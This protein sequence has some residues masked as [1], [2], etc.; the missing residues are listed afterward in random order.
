[1]EADEKK[2]AQK[3]VDCAALHLRS[4]WYQFWDVKETDW[5]EP[6]YFCPYYTRG[7]LGDAV[8]AMKPLMEMSD[9]GF[10][11]LY[12]PPEKRN[13][14]KFPWKRKKTGEEQDQG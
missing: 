11:Y 10:G 4:F 8:E 12:I 2:N 14:E 7:C 5:M 13:W 9:F 6:C 3:A 1:M